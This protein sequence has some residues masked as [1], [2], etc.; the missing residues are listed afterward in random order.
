[1][2]KCTNCSELLPIDSFAW[3]NKSKNTRQSRC[4]CCV[5]VLDQKRYLN[6]S[7]RRENIKTNKKKWVISNTKW[8]YDFLS[9]N[10]CVD[11]GEGDIRCLDF[12]HIKNG[13]VMNISEMRIGGYCL[14]TIKREI[15]K[16]EVRCANCHRKIT[17]ARRQATKVLMDA[18]RV[19]ASEVSD[20]Y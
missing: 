16:C 2:K 10:P 12:D 17:W 7:L 18:H 6:D 9:S 1:M 13:K 4:K 14:E 20:R 11:C 3:K 19:E 15:E 8:I 5:N